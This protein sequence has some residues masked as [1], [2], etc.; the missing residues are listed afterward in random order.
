MEGEGGEEV[1]AGLMLLHFENAPHF[2]PY[3]LFPVLPLYIG[4]RPIN[5]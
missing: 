1:D 5:L 4:S 3:P 2:S